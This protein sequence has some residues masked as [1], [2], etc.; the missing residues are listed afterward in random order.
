VETKYRNPRVMVTFKPDEYDIVQRLAAVTGTTMS[1]AVHQ[2]LEAVMPVLEKVV[3]SLEAAQ[4]TAGQGRAKL[5]A[6]ALKLHTEMDEIAAHALDQIDLFASAAQG[7]AAAS[8]AERS[9]ASEPPRQRAEKERDTGRGSG[10]NRS[11]RAV[12]PQGKR[13]ARKAK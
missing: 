11:R 13:R 10:A 5:M 9:E 4:R 12:K 8:G 1:K 3:E 7:H 2:Q 6:Q